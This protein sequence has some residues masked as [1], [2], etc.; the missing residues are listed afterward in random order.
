LPTYNRAAPPKARVGW[1]DGRG[2]S[3]ER[4]RERR[5]R[6]D[7]ERSFFR[8]RLFDRLFDRLLDRL[9][10]LL[11]SSCFSR[12]RLREQDLLLLLD[13]EEASESSLAMVVA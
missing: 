8:E 10:D 2:R 1:P 7:R 9:R 4:L 11:S 5:R 13:T 6:R 12:R 3:R